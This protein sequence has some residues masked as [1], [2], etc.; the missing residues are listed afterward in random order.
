MMIGNQVMSAK[1]SW[2]RLEASTKLDI[3]FEEQL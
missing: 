3:F 2:Y 1:H